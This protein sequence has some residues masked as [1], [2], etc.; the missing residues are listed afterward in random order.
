MK[1]AFLL[2]LTFALAGSVLAASA[3]AF[4]KGAAELGIGGATSLYGYNS[5]AV[6]YNPAL[7]NRAKFRLDVLKIGVIADNEFLNLVK[8]IEDHQ[9]EFSKFDSLSRQEQHAFLDDMAQ[10][11]DRWYDVNISPMFGLTFKHFGLA[12]ASQ[13]SPAV[14]LDRGILMPA[15]GLKGYSDVSIYAGYGNQ[16]EWKI[17][18]KPRLIEYGATLKIISRRELPEKRIPATQIG[19]ESD[20]MKEVQDDLNKKR[21]GVGIDAGFAHKFNQTT[22]AAVVIHDL[23]T[24]YDGKIMTPNVVI[25][26]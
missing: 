23:L 2:L 24:S 13:T 20:V 17:L 4:R 8:F 1:K 12:V 26:S 11:D 3:P 5:S 25:G 15:V 6:I 10:F 19:S 22:E 18:G 7:L 16:H 21:S 14:K 9:T